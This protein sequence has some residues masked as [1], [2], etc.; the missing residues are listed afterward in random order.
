MD[1]YTPKVSRFIFEPNPLH[2]QLPENTYR[3]GDTIVILTDVGKPVFATFGEESDFLPL[4]ATFSILLNKAE[5][6]LGSTSTPLYFRNGKRQLVFL[7]RLEMWFV[8][9]QVSEKP[10]NS[11]MI[12]K[13]LEFV[14]SRVLFEKSMQI[15]KNLQKNASFD[16]I[17]K[18]P[19]SKKVMKGIQGS[20][21]QHFAATLDL[22][23]L[24]PLPPY[25][26]KNI[27]DILKKT[28]NDGILN[29]I[30]FAGPLL[31]ACDH[32]ESQLSANELNNIILESNM[33]HQKA[34]TPLSVR[35]CLSCFFISY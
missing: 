21:P 30:L 14:S 8:Y 34:N 16:V 5:I 10:W 15:S 22:I 17:N 7:K 35:R 27:K 31:V 1:N 29:A 11:L 24:L 2:Q 23:P 3:Q 28:R 6:S 33:L 20:L 13:T 32:Q 26:R 12:H 4:F 19:I 9:V 25:R 18:A